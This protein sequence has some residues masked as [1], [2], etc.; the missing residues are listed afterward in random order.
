M[1]SKDSVHEHRHIVCLC[2]SPYVDLL[3]LYSHACNM[4]S[5]VG[6]PLSDV[7]ASGG[8]GTTVTLLVT[9]ATA[10]YPTTAN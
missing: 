10:N 9:I 6:R 1:A 3:N 4:G 7:E 5:K 2:S 8:R